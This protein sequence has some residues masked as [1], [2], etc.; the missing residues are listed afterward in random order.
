MTKLTIK[1]LTACK[2]SVLW[3][4]VKKDYVYEM[5]INCNVSYQFLSDTSFIGII[6]KE[7]RF[8]KNWHVSPGWK[9][10]AKAKRGRQVVKQRV[11]VDF[12]T[13][14]LN[15]ELPFLLGF[16][17]GA[18]AKSQQRLNKSQ[19]TACPGPLARRSPWQSIKSTGFELR[20]KLNALVYLK[21]LLK[22][23]ITRLH[24]CLNP[25]ILDHPLF[26]LSSG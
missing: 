8:K 13:F 2:Q 15:A 14:K 5:L 24:F 25:N 20:F 26:N 22:Q 7:L 1:P 17:G 12:Y 18:G 19:G 9:S 10:E 6:L 3:F 16:A 11:H 4:N 21:R 23:N